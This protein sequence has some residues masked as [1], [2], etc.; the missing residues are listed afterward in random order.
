MAQVINTNTLSLM[1]QNNLNKS[2]SALSTA[3]E[4]LSS[5][6]RI[7][8][9]KD[10][11]AGQ[12][13]ANRFTSNINGLTQASR[14]ANDGI[15]V[16]Q[17]TEGSLSEINNNLQ[18]IRE[19]SVQAAN[20]TNSSSDL[21]SIQDEITS[22]LSEIDRVSGQT[23]FNGVNVLA[24]NQTMKIQVGA[25][26][27][28]TISIDLQ[29]IDSTTLG[30]NGFSVSSNALKTSD[31]ITQVG[32]SGS[33]KNVDLSAAAT[34]LGLDAS[35]LS[36]K[37]V[38]TA[39][40]AATATYVVSDGTNNYAA[41]VDD[42][43]GAVT[44]N[45]TDVS[46]T[47]TDNGVTAGTQT[48]KLVKVGADATGAAVGYVTVQGKDYK[49]AAGAITD[50]GATG[51][52]NV[53]STIGDISDTANTNAYTGVATSDPLKAI[54]AAIA[55]VDTF[56]SSLGAVQ[57]R[58]DSAITNLDNTTTNLSSAQS[59]IQDADYATEVSAM[60]KAQILQQAGTSVLSKANQ[61][62]QSVLSLLQ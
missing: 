52:A 10:D 62:P 53:A 7:N 59:R 37:N 35:K 31:A 56:R 20:G 17:T 44:L 61:V 22:R 45:T 55:K 27:G 43:T 58:F 11:A 21:T 18:R 12:A 1:T 40:G 57:N 36:L 46:Y 4:R 49:T 34:S 13:I 14:N 9:A 8:S 25:N 2:Q 33:L 50:G 51:T 38:Q 32:A 5:G 15:S 39:A 30:L 23:Q 47:D 60:S 29:K 28:Q 24:S 6:L 3:I 26:D 42:A 16:A 54:D 19:L 41:S 48:G